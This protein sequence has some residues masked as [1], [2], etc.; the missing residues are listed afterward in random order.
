MTQNGG[1][2]WTAVTV[3]SDWTRV[4]IP[5][6]TVTDPSVG[7]R[8]VTS[9]DAIAVDGVQCENGEFSTSVILTTTASV[10]RAADSAVVTPISS[11]YN[12]AEGTLFAE[13]VFRGISDG[14]LMAFDDSTGDNV[15]RLSVNTSSLPALVVT[16]TTLQAGIT[17]G[18]AVTAPAS[19]TLIGAVKT[20]DFQAALGGVLGTADTSGTLSSSLTRLVLGFRAGGGT[21]WNGHIRKVAYWPKRLTNT[22]LEQLT[23]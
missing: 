16:T 11:F 19:I 7:F 15:V 18:S 21:R 12:P 13:G 3:T 1:S 5:S 17:I 2:T 20:D 4:T 23:T 10:T 8:I 6:A 9:G 22:L 14:T